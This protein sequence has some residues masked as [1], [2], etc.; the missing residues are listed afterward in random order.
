MR[1]NGVRSVLYFWLSPRGVDATG[2]KP[3]GVRDNTCIIMVP[4]A[5][6]PVTD[7][8]SLRSQA[9]CTNGG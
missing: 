7:P 8:R 4:T 5:Q 3:Y 2:W 6:E 9:D 1:C